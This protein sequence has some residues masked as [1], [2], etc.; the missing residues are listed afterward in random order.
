MFGTALS[1]WLLCFLVVSAANKTEYGLECCYEHRRILGEISR[2]TKHIMQTPISYSESV[3]PS[4]HGIPNHVHFGSPA[5]DFLDFRST[6]CCTRIFFWWRICVL[7]S[8]PYLATQIRH[9]IFFGRRPIDFGI[10]YFIWGR[11]CVAR[12]NVPARWCPLDCS[13]Y[14]LDKSGAH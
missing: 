8:R 2:E 12:Q 11:V 5:N 4:T 1:L 10:Q 9:R 3:G 14:Y 6:D 13:Y 7:P